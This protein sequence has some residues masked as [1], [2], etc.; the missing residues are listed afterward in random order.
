M[1]QIGNIN[2][3]NIE[4]IFHEIGEPAQESPVENG[5]NSKLNYDNYCAVTQDFGTH[6][7]DE[8]ALKV[9]EGFGYPR[10]LVIDSLHN[11]EL[12]HATTCYNL[13]VT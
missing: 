9:L 7:I 11:G 13:L 12:N 8:E 3:I 1:Q 6:R 5:A 2:V 10:K 4:N